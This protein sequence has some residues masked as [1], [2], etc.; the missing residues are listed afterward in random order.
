MSLS[1]LLQQCHACFVRFIWMVLETGG[2]WP[3]SSCFVGCCFQNL[4]NIARRI[5]MQF[6]ARF[7]SIRLF[8]ASRLLILSS[9]L[10]GHPIHLALCSSLTWQI[11]ECP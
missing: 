11:I 7:F 1:L 6:S 9:I 3:Y 5:L 4:F 2:R 10:I 8:S